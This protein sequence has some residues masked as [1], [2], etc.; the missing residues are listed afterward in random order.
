MKKSLAQLTNGANKI[1]H[2]VSFF[3]MVT[4]VVMMGIICVDIVLGNFLNRPLKGLY[5]V[6]Q[7]LLT[8]LVFASWGYT[9]SV[10]GHIH[11]VMFV[12]RMPQKLRFI[13]YGLTASF[14]TVVMAIGCGAVCQQVLN[15]FKSGEQT[16][17][18]SIPYWPFY[19]FEAVAFALLTITLLLDAIKAVM[20]IWDNEMAEE[21]QATW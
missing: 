1:C 4:I 7:V 2:Y 11:V 12:T 10:H 14:S 5:E 9:Q 13:C 3:S 8:T 17:T 16:G 20:A 6:L 21:I 15:V 18:L 19:I